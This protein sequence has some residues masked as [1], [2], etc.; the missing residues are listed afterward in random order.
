MK[1]G[2]LR[3]LKEDDKLIS[4]SDVDLYNEML[5]HVETYRL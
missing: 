3:S 4:E 2:L 5:Q 1:R